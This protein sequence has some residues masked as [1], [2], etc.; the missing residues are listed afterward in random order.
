[1]CVGGEGFEVGCKVDAVLG[2]R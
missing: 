2:G 1:M